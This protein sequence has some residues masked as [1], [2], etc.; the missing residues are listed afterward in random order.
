MF[1]IKEVSVFIMLDNTYIEVNIESPLK[2][3][4]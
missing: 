2:M 3:D 4:A 1:K